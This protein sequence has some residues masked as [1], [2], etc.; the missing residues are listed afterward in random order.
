MAT[1]VKATVRKVNMIVRPPRQALK[2]I[3][4]KEPRVSDVSV[5]SMRVDAHEPSHVLSSKEGSSENREG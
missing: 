5:E 3:L 2:G 4:D 1:T